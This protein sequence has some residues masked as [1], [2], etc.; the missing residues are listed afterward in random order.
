VRRVLITGGTG[1]V[2]SY[3]VRFLKSP[4]T[5]IIAVSSGEVQLQEPDVDYCQADICNLDDVRLFVREANPNEIYHLAAVSAVSDSWTDPR[6]TFDVN[7]IGSHNVFEAAMSLSSPPRILN[8]STSQVYAPSASALVE[9]NPLDPGNPYAATKAMAELLP[10]QYRKVTTG[11]II[12]ARSFNH[13][14]P[15][16]DPRFVLPSFAKQLSEMEAGLIPPVLKV[17]NINVK[18]DFTDVRDV[19]VA[20]AALLEKGKI[21]EI[22]NVC[23][24][25]AVPLVDIVTELQRSCSATVK[26]EV[27]HARLRSS[28]PPQVVG[29]PTKIWKATGWSPRVTLESTLND[30]L[31]YWRTKVK[32]RVREDSTS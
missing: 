20:Y 8:V 32:L 7:V 31:D 29:D 19:I 5:K 12:T 1:F 23:S 10:V 15:G 4:D 11:G 25:R 22:Y 26:I 17:G 3:L 6:R 28:D 2:G 27:D 13:T 16:Q 21:G 24:G 9:T 14:G 30:L 18:R